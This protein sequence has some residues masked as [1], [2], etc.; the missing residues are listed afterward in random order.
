VF[1]GFV[2]MSIHLW[3]LSGLTGTAPWFLYGMLAG[4]IELS[5]RAR[6]LNV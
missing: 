4:V 3:T 2:T 6:G 5:R 1:A